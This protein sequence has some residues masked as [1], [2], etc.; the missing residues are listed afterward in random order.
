MFFDHQHCLLDMMGEDVFHCHEVS[1]KVS[2]EGRSGVGRYLL[3]S[4]GPR[5][6]T[7]RRD[8]REKGAEGRGTKRQS[9]S[10]KSEE[11]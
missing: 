8:G 1:R 5:S 4:G 10:G 6:Q 11:L 9:G 2:Q 3:R 7:R